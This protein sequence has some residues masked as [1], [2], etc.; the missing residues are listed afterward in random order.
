MRHLVFRFLYFFGCLKLFPFKKGG[1]KV[2]CFHRVSNKD[3]PGYKPLSPD[4]FEKLISSLSQK[5][6]FIDFDDIHRRASQKPAVIITFDDA[7]QD[8]ETFALPILK[9]FDAPVTLNVIASCAES[10]EPHWTQKINCLI[11]EF[12]KQNTF[13]KINKKTFSTL[14]KNINEGSVALEVFHVLKDFSLEEIDAIIE[15][16]EKEL[17]FNKK[18]YTQMLKWSNLKNILNNSDKVHIGNHTLSHINLKYTTNPSIIE[19]EIIRSH[20]IIEEK[21]NCKINRF[22]FPNGEYNIKS[23]KTAIDFK[24]KYIQLTEAPQ[25]KLPDNAYYRV[26][27]FFNSFEENIFKIHGFHNFIKRK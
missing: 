21:L 20:Q 27:P 17:H 18:N 10:G 1:V 13:P 3:N 12:A 4:V 7:F 25:E 15:S 5:V 16:W 26:E 23:L 9:K 24:Y 8:F 2:L 19:R 6:D 14:K 22:A 11:E